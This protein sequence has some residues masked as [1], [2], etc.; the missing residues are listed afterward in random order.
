MGETYGE[1]GNQII[2]YDI[3]EKPVLCYVKNT[4]ELY[5]DRKVIDFLRDRLPWEGMDYIKPAAKEYF[6]SQI[7]GEN[8]IRSVEV[9]GIV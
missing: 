9:A 5:I 1:V 4:K 3:H 7:E 6:H 2:I 8:E